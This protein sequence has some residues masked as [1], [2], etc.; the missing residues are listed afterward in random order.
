MIRT[1]M[2]GGSALLAAGALA[3][4]V[5][6]VRDYARD[7]AALRLERAA[8]IAAEASL[9]RAEEA[10]EVHRAHL[11]RAED[12]LRALQD[13]RNELQQMEGRDAPLSPLLRTTA[14][15]LWPAE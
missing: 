8:R 15:R 5:W 12:Q 11:A 10:A 4:A 13:I 3:S 1:F 9:E 2:R 14:D 6:L 7:K